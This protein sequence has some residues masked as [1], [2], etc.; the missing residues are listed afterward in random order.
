M[1]DST[2]YRDYDSD[3]TE[4]VDFAPTPL[5]AVGDV[6]DDRYVLK[7][8]ISN[9]GSANT[10]EGFDKVLARPV[11]INSLDS[12]HPNCDLVIEAAKRSA[13]ATDSRF[14]RVLDT[15]KVDQ[16]NSAFV[17]SEFAPGRPI[18]DL[19]VEGPLSVVES[20][21]I[22]R[23]LSQALAG[24]HAQ[25]LYHL[26]IN[27]NSVIV[28]NSG[29][30]KLI[31]LL[32]N[33]ALTAHPGDTL[34]SGSQR[35]AVDVRDLGR[36]LYAMVVWRWPAEA[37]EQGTKQWGLKIAPQDHNG[38]LT[39]R[40]VKPGISPSIDVICDQILSNVP[41]HNEAPINNCTDLVTALDKVLGM[42]NASADLENRVRAFSNRPAASPTNPS[43]GAG[44]ADVNPPVASGLESPMANSADA[45]ASSDPGA[46]VG[47]SAGK[48]T[49][50]TSGSQNNIPGN[51]AVDATGA[52]PTAKFGLPIAERVSTNRRWLGILISLTLAFGLIC[53]IIGL[54]RGAGSKPASQEAAN[55]T[56]FEISK[57][58]VFD[59]E[60]DGG[61]AQENDGQAANAF[62]SNPDT[63]W[64][65]VTYLN[66]PK[67][68]GLK[69]GV[70]LV[71]DLGSVKNIGSVSLN[72][73]EQPT[74]VSLYI[75]AGDNAKADQ[76]P[77]DTIKS[78]QQISKLP[79]AGKQA[80]FT[81][82]K[83]VES[84][85]L[86]VHLSKLPK[87]EKNKY[88]GGIAEIEIKPAS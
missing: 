63:V 52:S 53:L 14:L 24:V 46:V 31:G 9:C 82:D 85:Y 41:R 27:P 42:V 40:Q 35:E 36:L 15:F 13:L 50:A 5:L 22:I 30:V 51:G 25:E 69:P 75:P 48:N 72:L 28:T 10:W 20:A 32:V 79:E 76:P 47:F 19:L 73:Y 55:K 59:P 29:S 54:V 58:Y 56:Y 68:G 67:M 71:F 21:W 39:P 83:P 44:V 33:A 88:Q 23:E 81:L 57:A 77:M 37:N 11:L 64:T 74:E 78:W 2:G 70:G 80:D 26:R 66:N 4:E 87:V 6:V 49:G 84:R 60:K 16:L 34:L 65:T 18:S 62:D 43:T 7:A 86:L 3:Q 12:N 38:W 1:S 45:N 8:K 61:D 17:V